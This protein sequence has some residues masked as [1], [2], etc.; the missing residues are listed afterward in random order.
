MDTQEKL[1]EILNTTDR[2]KVVADFITAGGDKIIQEVFNQYVAR[3]NNLMLSAD[4]T[5]L[6]ELAYGVKYSTS[7]AKELINAFHKLISVDK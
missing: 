3:L 6:K 7:F 1:I 2:R 4:D 5:K